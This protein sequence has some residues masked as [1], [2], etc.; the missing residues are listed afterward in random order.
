MNW[1]GWS[2][3]SLSREDLSNGRQIHWPHISKG[4][5][6]LERR[7]ACVTPKDGPAG[8]HWERDTGYPEV[9][10]P[11]NL[12]VASVVNVTHPQGHQK[13]TCSQS[14]PVIVAVQKN[15]PHGNH[16]E[17]Q[18]GGCQ[19]WLTNVGGLKVHSRMPSGSGIIL[20]LGIWKGKEETGKVETDI[21]RKGPSLTSAGRR[22]CL[23][24]CIWTMALLLL[25]PSKIT[26]WSCFCLICC[27]HRVT[28]SNSGVLWGC[29]CPTGED[30]GPAGAPGHLLTALRPSCKQVLGAAP[31]FHDHTRKSVP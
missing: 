6:G 9:Q 8:T 10:C 23:A 29:S 5:Q 16:E 26:K 3:E 25:C 30:P 22:D 17:S 15:T 24:C 28:L 7:V 11:T 1:R 12:C 21:E 13:H 14:W 27:S 18:W 4:C 19:E 2:R 31:V 20:Q